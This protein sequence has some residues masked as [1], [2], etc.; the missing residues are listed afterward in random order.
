MSEGAEHRV[1]G[2]TSR[3]KGWGIGSRRAGAKEKGRDT[4]GSHLLSDL[5]PEDKQDPALPSR[6]VQSEGGGNI[7]FRH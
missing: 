6:S 3:V 1:L 5:C 2:K 7:V 4:L